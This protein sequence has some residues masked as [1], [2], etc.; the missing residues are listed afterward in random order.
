MSAKAESEAKD[1]RISLLFSV[2]AS[3]YYYDLISRCIGT[4][5]L[6]IP[7]NSVVYI[8]SKQCWK[9]AHAVCSSSK[10]LVQELLIVIAAVQVIHTPM[11]LAKTQM[12]TR[13]Y[14]NIYTGKV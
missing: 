5:S 8:W 12:S 9:K 2:E 10:H 14:S 1:P 7:K 4:I 13:V 6:W 3:D 11:C